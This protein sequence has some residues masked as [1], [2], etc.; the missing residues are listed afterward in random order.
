MLKAARILVR[1]LA[2]ALSVLTV[3]ACGQTGS[4]Y[5]PAKTAP[6]NTSA[7]APKAPA[8]NPSSS[9]SPTP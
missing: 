1:H 7:A 3:A 5:L 4:L 2:L 9:T 8:A 6:R